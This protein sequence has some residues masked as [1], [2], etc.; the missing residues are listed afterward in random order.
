MEG[1]LPLNPYING[2]PDV[3]AAV[4]HLRERDAK[5]V[6]GRRLRLGHQDVVQMPRS[7]YVQ[8]RTCDLIDVYALLF[9]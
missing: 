4:V 9:L 6:S 3:P 7:F 8:L 2:R 5:K 1:E